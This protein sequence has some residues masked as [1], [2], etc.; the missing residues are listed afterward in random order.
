MAMGFL[1]INVILGPAVGPT[2]GGILIEHFNWRSIFYMGLPFSLVGILFGT[3]FMPQREETA[4]RT[5]FDWL[6]FA[7]LCITMSSLLTGLSNGQR[8]GW[9]SDFIV[10]MLAVAAL[11]GI[12]FLVW[13]LSV[14][15]PL[16]NIRVLAVGPFAAAA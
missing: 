12:A 14:T 15:H 13:E 5:Q 6:G 10:D 11:A 3:L 8:E 2:I 1:S 4:R 9:S 7:L 16:V